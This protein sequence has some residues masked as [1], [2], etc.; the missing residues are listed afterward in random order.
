M[1]VSIIEGMAN[2]SPSRSGLH[3]ERMFQILILIHYKLYGIVSD[4]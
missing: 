3:K 1:S 4:V 2:F